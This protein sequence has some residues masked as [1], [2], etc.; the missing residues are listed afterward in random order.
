MN[1]R[2]RRALSRFCGWAAD[3]KIPTILRSP[4]YKGYAACFGANLEEAR[5][6]LTIYPS[7]S[8]FF[9]RTLVP[10]ARS[11]TQD[12]SHWASPVDG[13]VQ[14]IDRIRN[15]SMLQAKGRSY[16]ATELLAHRVPA[17][18]LEGALAWTIYLGP[19]DYHRVHAPEAGRLVRVDWVPGDRFSVQPAVLAQRA[20]LD[21]NERCVLHFET[22]DGPYYL[23]MVGA[24][25]VGRIR[26]TGVEPDVSGAL[27]KPRPVE[28]G[29]EIGRF[30]MGSTIVLITPD[31][32]REPS[33]TLAD[34]ARVRMGQ[35]IG[36]RVAAR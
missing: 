11:V 19:R 16:R 29:D 26:I 5:G 34:G 1:A 32:S 35:P 17:Q 18:E 25:N 21:V 20:V 10:G 13:T 24:L 15:D 7:L 4:I 14:T 9:V 3:R 2:M 28:R 30:E 33:P 31:R 36:Y 6:P 12:P 27:A 22:P 8:A 23:V